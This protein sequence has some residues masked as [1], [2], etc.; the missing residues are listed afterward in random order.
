MAACHKQRHNAAESASNFP[1]NNKHIWL[2]LNGPAKETRLN[3]RNGPL[4]PVRS[5]QQDISARHA[6]DSSPNNKQIIW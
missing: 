6:S 3:T 4:W 5:K 2:P 1:S